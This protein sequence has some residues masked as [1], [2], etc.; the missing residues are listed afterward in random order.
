[1]SMS[2]KSIKRIIDRLN[3]GDNEGIFLQKLSEFVEY[4]IVWHKVP[5][6]SP[7]KGKYDSERRARFYFIKNENKLYVGAVLIMEVFNEQDDLHVYILKQHRKQ[8]HL[9]RAMNEVILPHLFQSN[10]KLKITID[11]NRLSEKKYKNSKRS[12][13]SLGFKSTDD[14]EFVLFKSDI[15]LINDVNVEMYTMTLDR[16]KEL[17]V[18]MEDLANTVAKIDDEFKMTLGSIPKLGELKQTL[19][20]YSRYKLEDEYYKLKSE[21]SDKNL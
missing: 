14:F 6:F 19:E 15:Q 5:Q 18:Q 1:M 8:G 20:D 16:V 11:D 13:L 17:K 7:Y 3:V 12:A 4:G 10:E 21:I 2:D 9:F